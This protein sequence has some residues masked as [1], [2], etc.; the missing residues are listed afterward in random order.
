MKKI[1]KKLLKL[2]KEIIAFLS[3]ESLGQVKGGDERPKTL[4]TCEGPDTFNSNCLCVTNYQKT[5]PNYTQ[6][7]ECKVASNSHG[8]ICCPIKDSM[9]MCII[10]ATG[11]EDCYVVNKTYF[12]SP[13]DIKQTKGC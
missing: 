10:P 7:S 2:D 5:C 1:N 11:Q 4:F 9:N 6:A 3:E 8:D 12:C 13:T